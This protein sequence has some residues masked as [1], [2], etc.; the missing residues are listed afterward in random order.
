MAVGKADFD[1]RPTELG[2]E[3]THEHGNQPQTAKSEGHRHAGAANDGNAT[4]TP[5]ASLTSVGLLVGRHA[6]NVAA[7]ATP[8]PG[9]RD[10]RSKMGAIRGFAGSAIFTVVPAIRAAS[11]LEHCRQVATRATPV[12]RQAACA[13]RVRW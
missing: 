10:S 7:F 1:A 6:A 12:L 8:L 5:L 13:C 2:F 9:L 11:V 4:P 3:W